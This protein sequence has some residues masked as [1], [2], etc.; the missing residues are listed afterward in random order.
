MRKWQPAC[1]QALVVYLQ[2]VM[3]LPQALPLALLN[4]PARKVSIKGHQRCC[5]LM[6]HSGITRMQRA[7][8]QVTQQSRG[9][10]TLLA[11]A[12][13]LL[14]LHAAAIHHLPCSRSAHCTVGWSDGTQRSMS[15]GGQGAGVV[16]WFL[17][18]L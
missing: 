4:Q 13:L 6:L 8:M 2:V 10:P 17:S 3:Q 11:A 7:H 16:R 15:A 12:C 18:M 9:T 14:Q 1:L 5:K